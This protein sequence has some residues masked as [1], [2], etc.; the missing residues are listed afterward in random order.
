MNRLVFVTTII[1]GVASGAVAQEHQHDHGAAPSL[2]APKEGSGTSWLPASSEM[3]ALHRRTGQ[4]EWMFHG[5]AF[6]QFLHEEANTHRGSSQTGSINWLMVM[7]RRPL[8]T[9]NVGLRAMVS[10]E[11]LTIGGCGYPDLLATGELCDRDSIHDLQ[12]PHDFVMELAGEYVRPLR[13]NTRW[14]LYGGP[15]GEPA[16]G[17]PSYPHRLSA[18]PN[19]IAPIGHH[20]LDATHITFG[21]VTAGVFTSRWKAEAS[22]FNGREPDENRWDLDLAAM[23]SFS[24]RVSFAPNADLVAQVSAGH[25]N[26]AEAGEGSL[27]PADVDRVT[28]SVAYYR[29]VGM[30]GLWANTIAWGRNEERGIAT[31]A[32]LAEASVTLNERDVWFGRFEVAGKP[33]HDLHIHELLNDVLTVGKLQGGYTRYFAGAAGLRFG[34]GGYLS[35]GFVPKVIEP[36][37]GS[38]ANLGGGFFV[39]LRPRA[40]THGAPQAQ[41]PAP[42][43]HVMVQTAYDPAK[44]ACSPAIDPKTAAQT[45]YQ[46]RTYYFC[47]VKDRDEFLTN[48]AMSLTMM[49]PRQ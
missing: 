46:G 7:A 37:Y 39:T 23:N 16:L 49:P 10:L 1:L 42:A 38:R 27:P 36:Q 17:P 43:A 2:F 5:N 32:F 30:N 31:Q 44:L 47:S 4:W 6:L 12:H 13:G 8:G 22:L 28:A 34:V 15:V 33:A 24:G 21:V 29:R 18:M 11:P 41:A 9:A 19:P 40:M 20:W 35:A 25:L 3:Y 26:D 45:T 48:P 14:Q